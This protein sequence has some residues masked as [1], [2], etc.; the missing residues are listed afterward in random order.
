MEGKITQLTNFFEDISKIVSNIGRELD[1]TVET[2]RET[3]NVILKSLKN[4]GSDNSISR[5]VFSVL[6][7]EWSGLSSGE[8]ALIN[9]FGRLNS[10]KNEVR[11][12][13]VLLLDEVDLGLHPE[14]QRKWVKNILPIIGKIMKSQ[15]GSVRVVVTTHSPIILSDFMKK[16]I[17]YLY[18]IQRFIFL[19]SP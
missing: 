16:D 6:E 14:W 19:R 17:I 5:E 7:F 8:L 4:E 15:N 12:N 18:S 11:K 13:M 9:L 2:D 3:L 10:I 1:F